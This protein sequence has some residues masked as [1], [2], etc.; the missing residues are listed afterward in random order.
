MTTQTSRLLARP[1]LKTPPRI[2]RVNPNGRTTQAEIALKLIKH[3][4]IDLY[5]W[6]E[7][8]FF[9]WLALNEHNKYIHPSVGLILPRQNGKSK[10]VI[11]AR[12]FVGAV[13]YGEKIRYTAHRVD[14]MLEMWDI[15]VDI[16]GDT[17]NTYARFPELRA[18]VA[19]MSHQNGHRH[20]TLKNGGELIFSARSTGAGRGNTIDVMIY[21][22]AQYVTEVQQAAAVP[23]L[24]AGKRKN[25]QVIYVGTPPDYIESHGEVFGNVRN[26]AI[27]GAEGIAWHE[28]SVEKIGDVSDT[29]RWYATNPS[30]GLSLMED[31]VRDEYNTMKPE[32]FARERL[33]YWA[34]ISETM[35]IN[36]DWWNATKVDGDDGKFEKFCVGVKF[37]PNG[38]QISMSAAKLKEDGTTFCEL[39]MNECDTTNQVEFINWIKARKDKIALVAIDGKSGADE[40]NTR[41]VRAGL[42]RSAVKV[43]TTREVVTA[44]TMLTSSLEERT[45]E[46]H[47]DEVLDLSAAETT[48]RKIGQDGYGFGDNSIPIESLSFA[49]WAA[50]TT[51][52][53]A[54]SQR[55]KMRIL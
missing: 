3:Y 9:T 23:S 5:D 26:N 4:I 47:D 43:M 51:N 13:L 31:R 12:M 55:R 42:S 10:A 53:R 54:E 52:R 49:N 44:A 50:R 6:Q 32:A 28:W 22:E 21:D 2:R 35:A 36:L 15:F 33:A 38:A 18:L 11:A 1:Q 19:R 16:F 30:L 8:V 46:H 48:R 20:I 29:T 45:M 24:S 40:L 27:N 37:A 25:S 17:R 7:D 39:V 34:P 41:L 14:T